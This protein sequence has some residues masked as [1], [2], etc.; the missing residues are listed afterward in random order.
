MIYGSNKRIDLRILI[1][2]SSLCFMIVFVAYLSG[3][4]NDKSLLLLISDNLASSVS[5][6]ALGRSSALAFLVTSDLDDPGVNGA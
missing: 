1:S 2:S 6:D 3:I 5:L 4:S